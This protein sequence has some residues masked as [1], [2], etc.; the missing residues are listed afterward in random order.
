VVPNHDFQLICSATPHSLQ[1]LNRCNLTI[2][3]EKGLK[4]KKIVIAAQLVLLFTIVFLIRE[5][6]ALCITDEGGCVVI[7]VTGGGGSGG[8]TGAGPGVGG[9]NGG[10]GQEKPPNDKGPDS[11][12]CKELASAGRGLGCGGKPATSEPSFLSDIQASNYYSTAVLWSAPLIALA[13]AIYNTP[14]MRNAPVLVATA[15]R[16]SIDAC[17]QNI[18]CVNQVTQFFGITTIPVPESTLPF[19]LVPIINELLRL[20]P[21][22]NSPADSA[23][24]SLVNQFSNGFVCKRVADEKEKYQCGGAG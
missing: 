13:K 19:Q 11:P 24:G 21:V 7:V 12:K 1:Y 8:G 5:A 22:A 17:K 4:M 15:Y 20:T 10:G 6:N 18:T 23:A 3:V 2:F 9:G 14:D 16:D